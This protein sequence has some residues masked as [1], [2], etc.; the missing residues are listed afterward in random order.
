M[1]K[2]RIPQPL[3]KNNRFYDMQHKTAIGDGGSP[4]DP[5]NLEPM[6]H[7]EHME[8]HQENGDFARWGQR[9]QGASEIEQQAA[10]D[11]LTVGQEVEMQQRPMG[12]ESDIPGDLDPN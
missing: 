2:F 4:R 12:Q 11:G 8:F 10:R 3:L 1:E 5:N 7:D 6:Q 9:A